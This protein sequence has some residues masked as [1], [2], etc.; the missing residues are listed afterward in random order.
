MDDC[1]GEKEICN[2]FKNK[3]KAL[4]NS[5]SFDANDMQELKNELDTCIV[6]SNDNYTITSNDV[7]IAIKKL[8]IGKNDSWLPHTSDNIIHGTYVLHEYLSVLFNIMIIHGY[9]PY[10]MLVGTMVPLPK[11]KWKSKRDSDNYRAITLSSLLGKL[12]DLIIIFKEGEKLETDNLQFGYKKGL[13]TTMCTSILRETV[14]YYNNR[15]T[16]VYGLML[17]ATKA[18]DRVNYCKLFKI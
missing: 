1:R 2:V 10:G 4:Y 12:L 11:G 16:S 15:G 7:S 5:V 17:D 9:S 6:N 18:F 8:K 3:F 13:S 14:S